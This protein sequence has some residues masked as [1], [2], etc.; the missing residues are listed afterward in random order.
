MRGASSLASALRAQAGHCSR[1]GSP[2]YADLLQRAA[3]DLEEDGPVARVLDGHEAD[4]AGS[5]LALRLMGA[6][7]RRVLEGAQPDMGWPTFRRALIDDADAIRALLDRPVQTNDVGR[8]AALLPGFA[9]VAETTELPLRL[10][11]VGS[12]AGLNLLWDRYLYEADGFSWGD[13]VSPVRIDFRLEGMAPAAPVVE[14]AE[15]RGCDLRPLDPSSEG[16]RLTLLSF[17]WSDQAERLRRLRAAL[18]V[19]ADRPV[20]VDRAGAADWV[21]ARLADPVEGTATVVFHSIV[22]Q[23]LPDD[24]R[25]ELER[26]VLAAGEA[27]TGSAPLAWLR[28]EP[29]GDRA[30]VRLTCWPDGEDRLLARAGYHGDPVRLLA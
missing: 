27:A 11:E 17:V 22:M 15:R 6:V 14:I 10:L 2:L 13:P 4:P 5:A 29:A 7:H 25:R 24:E 30:E 18:A 3:A 19:A 20:A 1:L 23:Y 28:M 16:G 12:S 26:I 8:C 21:A 9:A